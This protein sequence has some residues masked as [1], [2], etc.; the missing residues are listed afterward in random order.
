MKNKVYRLLLLAVFMWSQIAY[1]EGDKSTV[2]ATR[3]TTKSFTVNSDA[4]VSLNTREADVSM[5]TWSQNK[6]EV[7]VT[8][9]VEAYDKEDLEKMFDEMKVDM[10]GSAS[11]INVESQL[12]FSCQTS[13]GNKK[14]I[15]TRKNG[16]ISV[17]DYSYSFEFKVPETNDL[18]IKNRFGKVI[19][20]AHTGKLDLELYEC[21][22]EAAQVNATEG[23]LSMRFS[24]GDVGKIAKLDLQAYE[25]KL[26]IADCELLNMNAK[27][28]KIQLQDIDV[29]KLSGYE[30]K[31]AFNN[32]GSLIGKQ[33]FGSLHFN[34]ARAMNLQ[35]YE[36][37]V[38]SGSIDSLKMN[39]A[40]FSSLNCGV[41]KYVTIT[42]GYESD[43]NLGRVYVLNSEDKFG[44]YNIGVLERSVNLYGYESKVS[45]GNLKKGFTEVNMNGKFN[46]ADLNV[47]QG[48]KVEVKA[49]VKFGNVSY[50]KEKLEVESTSNK[51]NSFKLKAKTKG[52]SPKSKINIMGYET[53][54]NINFL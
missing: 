25:C 33:N 36:L 32:T 5:T 45:I 23:L 17:K 7:K 54:A 40:K 6:V 31:I 16:T 26:N 29:M 14:R 21:K 1:A 42:C 37:A 12:N 2:S 34:Q 24:K 35:A 8:I 46:K 39:C 3:T 43:F 22:L 28:S 4:L 44:T 52:A 48:A 49:D 38:E 41:A 50:N 53:N 19:L 15:K 30:S 47:A 51:N 10:Q 27:F 9:T 18:N 20:G 13:F 11:A